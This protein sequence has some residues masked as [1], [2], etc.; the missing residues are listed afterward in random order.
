MSIK[1]V[2]DSTQYECSG[3]KCSGYFEVTPKGNELLCT[4]MKQCSCI[5]TSAAKTEKELLTQKYGSLEEWETAV[6]AYTSEVLNYTVIHY[7][8]SISA[9][10]E[11]F[12]QQDP[13][14]FNA[15]PKS[16]ISRLFFVTD[17]DTLILCSARKIGEIYQ[18]VECRQAEVPVCDICTKVQSKNLPKIA[19]QG[20]GCCSKAICFDCYLESLRT[21]PATRGDRISLF[22]VV[23]DKTVRCL[24]CRCLT[25]GFKFEGLL[26]GGEVVY[27]HFSKP[28]HFVRERPFFHKEDAEF[29]E[30]VHRQTVQVY[31]E[32]STRQGLVVEKLAKKVAE[33]ES[34]MEA[35]VANP[36]LM[37]DDN[38]SSVKGQILDGQTSPTNKRKI[39]QLEASIEEQEQ[40]EASI[41]EQ[42]I[43]CKG[44]AKELELAQQK[45][46]L[47]VVTRQY[48]QSKGMLEEWENWFGTKEPI[49]PFPPERFS[50][51]QDAFNAHRKV[52]EEEEKLGRLRRRLFNAREGIDGIENLDEALSNLG[53]FREYLKHREL[54]REFLQT[55]ALG[56]DEERRSIPEGGGMSTEDAVVVE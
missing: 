26:S 6:L 52:K 9:L 40:L 49:T 37:Q 4:K 16:K 55:K 51:F 5:P 54:F 1:K 46:Q 22:D 42:E 8:R 14:A 24:Y 50:E 2:K 47:E 36:D 32:Q 21:R 10:M 39:V 43:S 45:K 3:Q 13:K 23:Q 25:W 35:L 31:Q 48:S 30:F 28:P 53:L 19:T 11:P 27:P 34:E 56:P 41:E 17:D 7:A 15:E 29:A 18:H 20:G 33:L 38:S 12:C 44:A